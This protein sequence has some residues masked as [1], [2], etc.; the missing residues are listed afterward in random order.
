[1]YS[2]VENF[3][4]KIE[5]DPPRLVKFLE[6]RK[7]EFLTNI[8]ELAR[9]VE[10]VLNNEIPKTFPKYTMHDINH[11]IRVMENMFSLIPNIEEHD[12]LD[13][14]ILIYSALLHDIGMAV[15][16]AEKIQIKSNTYPYSDIV[17]EALLEKFCGNETE[18]MQEYIRKIHAIRSAEIVRKQYSNYF[19]IP[20]YPSSNIMEEVALICVAHTEDI[21][22][23]KQNLKSYDEKGKYKINPYFCGILLRLGD[24]S[25]FN[26]NRTPRKLYELINPENKSDEEWKSHFIIENSEIIKKDDANSQSYIAFYGRCSDPKIH[27]NVLGY[28]DWVNNEIYNANLITSTMNNRYKVSV[29]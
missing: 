17:F 2:A 9:N 14:T 27:R 18:A 23:L 15:T 26:S 22:F 11:S 8:Y 28:F 24:I 25:D 12:E 6:S 16:D 13:I 3:K 21:G 5:L 20:S 19:T 7:S 29:K 10:F 1:M 4:S